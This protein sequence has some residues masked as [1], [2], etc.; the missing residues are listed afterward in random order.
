M[1]KGPIAISLAAGSMGWQ[2]YGGGVFGSGFFGRCGFDMDHAVQLVG[3]GNYG[4]HDYWLVRNSWGR[5]WGESGYIRM[6]RYGEGK[7]P[8][9]V[10]R[11]PQDGSACDGDT[12][13][14]T[15]CG[16]CGILSASSYPTGVSK[17]TEKE[18]A[19]VV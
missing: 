2:L 19:T 9:G 4:K 3:Y 12:K 11:T 10:D 1:G 6:M 15:L 13:P 8:C 16:L 14:M 18:T 5:G 17:V 7:E